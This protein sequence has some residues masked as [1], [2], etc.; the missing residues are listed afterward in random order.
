MMQ[1]VRLIQVNL[2]KSVSSWGF[3]AGIL[4]TVLLLFTS[5]LYYD[6]DTNRDCSILQTFMQFSRTELLQDPRFCSYSVLRECVSGWLKMFI[7]MIAPFSFVTQQC[8]ERASGAARFSGIRLS[9]WGY[10]T[11]TFLSAMV[12]GGLVLLTGFGVFTIC[13]A[14]MFPDITAYDTALRESF[15][16]W[17]PDAYPLF[18]K[19]GYPYLTALRFLEMLL[20]GAVSAVP[21]CFMTCL[22]KNKYLVISIPFFLK[23]M[24]LQTI[25]R[26]QET[27]YAD[28]EHI[29]EHLLSVLSIVNPDAVSKASSY[30]T[31]IWKN[32]LFYSILLVSAYIVYCTVMN[33]RREYGT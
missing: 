11:G 32:I 3:Y 24:L 10:Q 17:I 28:W 6:Y 27:A 21:A 31:E 7:P 22:L 2:K 4:L 13:I 19:L 26:L 16:W 23:Y 1:T 33:R 18:S 29:D 9:R 15:E 14:F 8:A 20:Y 5:A 25:S 12:T 30:G